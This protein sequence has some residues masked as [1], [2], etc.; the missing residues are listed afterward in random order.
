MKSRNLAMLVAHLQDYLHTFPPDDEWDSLF[1]QTLVE[2][3]I[4]HLAITHPDPLAEGFVQGVIAMLKATDP[5]FTQW[6]DEIVMGILPADD[7]PVIV[8]GD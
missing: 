5:R 1:D 8:E 4:A 3:D 6:T 2:D 7:C